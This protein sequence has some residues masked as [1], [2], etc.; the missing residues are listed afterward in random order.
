LLGACLH[1]TKA[2]KGVLYLLPVIP[3]NEQHA[4]SLR[5]PLRS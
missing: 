5:Y 4:A 1:E 3:A 2:G